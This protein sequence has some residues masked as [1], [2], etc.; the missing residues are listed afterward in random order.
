MR[1]IALWPY[2]SK[3]SGASIFPEESAVENDD[4]EDDYLLQQDEGSGKLHEWCPQRDT[5]YAPT[6]PSMAFVNEN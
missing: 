1:C 6:P 2:S 5:A 3:L 4:D